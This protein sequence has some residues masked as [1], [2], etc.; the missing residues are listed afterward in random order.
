VT[1]EGAGTPLITPAWL[2]GGLR[3]VPGYLGAGGGRLTFV[4]D[5]PVFDAGLDE[6]TDVNWPWYWFGGGFTFRAAGQPYKVTF[7]RPNGMPSPNPSM[8]GAGV[9]VFGMLSGTS[10]DLQA[11]QGLADISTGRAAGKLW[12]QVL[13]G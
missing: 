1:D 6:I 2:I 13:P 5:T 7:V 9:G 12:R 8:L 4:S 10:H 3:N 11:L